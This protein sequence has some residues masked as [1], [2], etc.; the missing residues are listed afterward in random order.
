MLYKYTRPVLSKTSDELLN[1]NI[2]VFKVREIVTK[3]VLTK[4]F[5]IILY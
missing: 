4:Y 3:T 2:Y 1:T 5:W